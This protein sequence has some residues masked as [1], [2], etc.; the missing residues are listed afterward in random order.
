[1]KKKG[2]ILKYKSV[3]FFCL[4]LCSTFSHSTCRPYEIYPEISPEKKD[5][6]KN[7]NDVDYYIDE[8][9]VLECKRECDNGAN[10][11][12]DKHFGI[13]NPVKT[14]SSIDENEKEIQKHIMKYGSVV[15]SFIVHKDFQCYESGVYI[16]H[17][18]SMNKGHSIKILGKLT[19]E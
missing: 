15:A 2:K 5:C 7:F 4:I 18:E 1:M 11:K 10:Y 17:E 6:P 13:F 3:L 16:S 12:N 9:K 14:N 19:N 8:S